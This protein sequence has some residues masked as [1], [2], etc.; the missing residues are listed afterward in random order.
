MKGGHQPPDAPFDT[1]DENIQELG[2]LL[3]CRVAV[4]RD[5]LAEDDL[6]EDR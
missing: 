3:E 4:L 6:W 1:P 5:W 2:E